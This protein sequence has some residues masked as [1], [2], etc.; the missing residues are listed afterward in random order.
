MP[1]KL[2]ARYVRQFASSVALNSNDEEFS[3]VISYSTRVE[4][5]I[6]LPGSTSNSSNSS[7]AQAQW[8]LVLR[9]MVRLP[10]GTL[11]V[12]WWKE[13]FDAVV[14]AAALFHDAPYVPPI[15]GL[16]EWANAFPERIIHSREYRRPE[17]FAGKVP[18]GLFD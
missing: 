16:D 10:D 9:K 3:E 14:V 4:R 11:Q 12:D 13:E 15:P 7:S 17:M 6:K 1:Q 18:I 8:E 2:V 5:A